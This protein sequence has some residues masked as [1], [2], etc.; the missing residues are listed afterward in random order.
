VESRSRGLQ[1][2]IRVRDIGPLDNIVQGVNCCL[3][4]RQNRPAGI[5]GDDLEFVV[6]TGLENPAL[7]GVKRI[8][9][10]LI[11]LNLADQGFGIRRRIAGRL[12]VQLGAQ[13][14][15]FGHKVAQKL[16]W[17]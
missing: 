15:G 1:D 9:K 10:L 4:V 8:G 2:V 11:I 5:L 7:L 16:V 12:G 3:G 6:E 13:E 14:V 17:A